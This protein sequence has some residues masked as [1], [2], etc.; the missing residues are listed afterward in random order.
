MSMSDVSPSARLNDATEKDW[1]AVKADRYHDN[2]SFD[3]KDAEC[4][5]VKPLPNVPEG[6][7]NWA[8]HSD[9]DPVN[10][11]THYTHGGQVE[12]IDYI[13]QQLG[14]GM[15]DYLLGNIHKY[16]HRHQFKGSALQDLKKTEFYLR[17][18]IREHEQGG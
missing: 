6:E 12:A 4:T 9:P 14:S 1:D 10:H 5:L 7:F 17:R 13:A 2:R 8:P 11:P 18:L 15:R 3:P 16:L